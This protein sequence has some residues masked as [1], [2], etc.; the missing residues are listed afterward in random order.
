MSSIAAVLFASVDE[1]AMARG[2]DAR[3]RDSKSRGCSFESDSWPKFYKFEAYFTYFMSNN[4]DIFLGDL[5]SG[6]V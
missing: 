5:F 3:M 1:Y 6:K 2:A 4:S